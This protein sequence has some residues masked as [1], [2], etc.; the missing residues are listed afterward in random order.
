M[1]IDPRVLRRLL[2]FKLVM[3]GPSSWAFR[4]LVDIVMDFFEERFAL[5]LNESLESYS[6][7]A[8]ILEENACE[9]LHN[10]PSCSNLMVVGIYEKESQNPL[11]YALYYV[12]R[13]ENTLEIK[14]HSILDAMTKEKLS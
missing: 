4:E 2:N 13:G 7:E 6:L 11:A 3:E 8:S 9:L 14:I 5:I 1:S 10:E 12:Y